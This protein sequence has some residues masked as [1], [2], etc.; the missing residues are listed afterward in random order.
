MGVYLDLWGVPITSLRPRLSYKKKLEGY[1]DLYLCMFVKEAAKQS[2]EF[3]S[4]TNFDNHVRPVYL[5][6]SVISEIFLVN[7]DPVKQLSVRVT[8]R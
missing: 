4:H 3:L 7:T 8:Q 5:N 6:G 1:L 2:Y